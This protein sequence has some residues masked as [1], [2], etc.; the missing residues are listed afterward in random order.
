MTRINTNVSSLLAQTNLANA[1]NQLNQALTRLSTGL[2]I[3]SGA[4]DPAGL[5]AAN[6]LG[7]EITSSNQAISNTQQ[8]TNMI[9]TADSALGQVSTLLNDIQGLVT[10][11]ANSGTMSSDEIAANQSQIDSSL[12]AIN[13]IAQTTAFQGKNLVDGSLGFVV[14]G[15]GGSPAANLQN[16]QVNQA[17]LSGGPLNVTLAVTTAATQAELDTPV[18]TGGTAATTGPITFSGGGTLTLTAKNVGSAA[19]GYTL[20]FAESASVGSGDALVQV[21][22]KAITVYV[23]N[24]GTTTLGA[25]RTALAGN[26]TVGGL[27]NV[28]DSADTDVYT[29]AGTD[30][31]RTGD[32]SGGVDTGLASAS[33]F[34][35]SGNNGSQTFNFA[36]GTTITAMESAINLATPATGVTATIGGGGTELQLKSSGYGSSA[37]V[38]VNQISGTEN[39]TLADD[40]TAATRASGTDAVGTVNGTALTA[41]GQAVS[42]NTATLSLS[43]NATATGTWTFSVQGGGALFQIGPDVEG[44]QQVQI[45]IPSVDTGSLGGTAGR[46]YELGSG[47]TASLASN[48]GLA[49]QIVS[50][51]INQVSSLQGRLGAFEKDTLDSNVQ[52]LTDTVQNLTSAQSNI[53]DA[54]FAAESA[55]LTRAQ[56]LSQSATAVLAIANQTPQNVLTLLRNV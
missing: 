14:G 46:L 49:D 31:N 40:V 44:S 22:G 27:F 53:Q 24:T 43:A 3:N 52:N 42:L 9:D 39:F 51:A 13:Q 5:I 28:T 54:D 56:V 45:G 26:A 32:T 41:N 48:P 29:A 7:S 2:R 23:N 36:A 34:E 47:Q 11:A 19:N 16:L 50:A 21:N 12:S 17:N 8:A 37:F 20:N 38:N 10:Q 4:D 1:N 35:L 33:T 55:N 30:R 15:W 6:A 18:A 25:I